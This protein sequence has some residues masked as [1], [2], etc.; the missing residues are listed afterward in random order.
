MKPLISVVIPVYNGEKTLEAC[1]N[2][3]ID[4]DYDDF[5]IIIIDNGSIDRTYE[6][7]K[8]YINSK[9]KYFHEPLKGRGIAR[10]LGIRKS[11]GKYIAMIDSDCVA[12]KNWLTKISK[13][14]I[15]QNEKIVMGGEENIYYDKISRQ[16]QKA[17]GD[18]IKRSI[19]GNYI[20]H[21]DTKNII[22][23]RGVFINYRFDP[24]IKNCED[25]DLY[26][27]IENKYRVFYLPHVKV[28]HHHKLKKFDWF[29]TQADRGFETAKIYKKYKQNKH[30]MF[31]SYS[32]T[33]W[34]KFPFWMLLILFR[35]PR[36]FKFIFVT[37]T[38]WRLGIILY[39]F[40]TIGLYRYEK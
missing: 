29:N 20:K 26:L 21:I 10:N 28:K 18:L 27:Q 24:E 40:D 17:N 2:S 5:E 33:N 34:G 32:L 38:G 7:I 19:S 35:K 22:F 11:S 23:K 3:V 30:L 8:S 36:E 1:L 14:I 16:I 39:Y 31:I 6:I 13:P 4:Q 25:L 15:E 9:I 12:N 37:E